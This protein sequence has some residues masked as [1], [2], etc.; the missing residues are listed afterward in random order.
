VVTR[1]WILLLITL[2]FASCMGCTQT[3]QTI[4]PV[5]TEP[6]TPTPPPTPPPTLETPV[7]QTPIPV[8]V[9]TVE[10]TKDINSEPEEYI[11]PKDTMPPIPPAEPNTENI[12]FT[13]FRNEYFMAEYPST[14]TVENESISLSTPEI[15]QF[16]VDVFKR[17]ARVVSF[18]SEDR[19][20]SMRIL[21]KD[22]IVP[23]KSHYFQPTIA[24]TR[25]EVRKLYPNATID[26]SVFNY[27][28]TKNDQNIFTIKYDVIFQD[29]SEYY[30]Y[31]YTEEMWITFNHQWST[32]FITRNGN[33][34]DYK[35]LRNRMMRSVKTEGNQPKAWW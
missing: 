9:I 18:Q 16:G 21:V 33:L 4:T 5:D 10:P 22:W 17:D 25:D 24:S 19:N 34:D 11:E 3:Q 6:V 1:T 30:P 8:K 7:V 23:H 14:W 13:H 15:M 29:S 2:I 32:K 28:Y 31:A 20:V 35:E 12:N 26:S 27:Q